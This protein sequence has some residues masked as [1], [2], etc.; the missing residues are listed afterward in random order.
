MCECHQIGGPFIAEDPDC[1]IHGSEGILRRLDR[2]RDSFDS[3]V[4]EEVPPETPDH[5]RALLRRAWDAA[6]NQMDT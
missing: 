4:A 2:A 3:W 5:V 6:I 1:P